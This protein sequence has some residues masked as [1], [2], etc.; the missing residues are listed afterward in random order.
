MALFGNLSSFEDAVAL[1]SEDGEEVSYNELSSYADSLSMA[2]GSGVIFVFCDNCIEAVVGYIAAMRSD[3]TVMLLNASLEKKSL[4]LLIEAYQ[5]L[6]LFG[7]SDHVAMSSPFQPVKTFRR[8]VLYKAPRT[9]TYPIYE[10]LKLLLSTS[11]STG[12]P[13]AVRLTS[14]NVASNATAIAD[15]LNISSKDTAITTMP[16]SYSYGLSIINSHLL[17]GATIVLSTAAVIEKRFWQSIDTYKVTNF[18]GV[19]FIYEMLKKVGFAK[20]ELS[21]LTCITQAGGKLASNLVQD[22]ADACDKKGVRFVV[23]YG[24]TEATA[25]MSYMPTQAN[26]GKSNSIGK[27]IPGGHFSLSGISDDNIIPMQSEAELVYQ[28]PNV[29]L[30]YASHYRDLDKGDDNQGVLHTGDIATRDKDGF[31][32]VVGRV[33]R[34]IKMFGNRINLDELENSIKQNDIDCACVG[35]DDR[36]TVYTTEP[37]AREK[38]EKITSTH[39]GLR[40]KYFKVDVIESLPRSTS[41]KIQYNKLAVQ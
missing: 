17:V 19:P 25:R 24:Q 29:S 23:M 32:Y 6:Y 11:G 2:M 35:S 28:G 26:D 8:F 38:V 36:L 27:P 21:S 18:G 10:K 3:A 22:F 13:K 37:T 4:D 14:D 30:G 12:S 41:G 39:T 31:Y 5:P 40:A 16:M 33:K 9:P 1:I 34:F 20:R 7:P 15:Y